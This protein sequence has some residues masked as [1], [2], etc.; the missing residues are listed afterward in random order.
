MLFGEPALR[1]PVESFMSSATNMLHSAT[2]GIIVANTSK[3]LSFRR[4]SQILSRQIGY[5]L[6]LRACKRM[7]YPAKSLVI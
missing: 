5:F 2:S 6:Q 4:S 1:V 7:Y 3:P